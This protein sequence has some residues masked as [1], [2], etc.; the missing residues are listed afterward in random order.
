MG[1]SLVAGVTHASALM[2][3][4]MLCAISNR[5]L[6]RV[7]PTSPCSTPIAD[8]VRNTLQDL[9]VL[10]FLLGA[11]GGVWTYFVT[12]DPLDLRSLDLSARIRNILG[13]TSTLNVALCVSYS[14]F[15]A[16]GV[17]FEQGWHGSSTN[18]LYRSLPVTTSQGENATIHSN[19]PAFK[20][21][22]IQTEFHMVV[23]NGFIVSFI[24][25]TDAMDKNADATT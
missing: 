21:Q 23:K 22:S 11:F 17:L 3:G 10:T 19:S 5:W 18:K 4:V 12:C 14:I 6:A 9:V 1:F 7:L 16:F 24:D 2:L 15:F 25:S 20:K 8:T 13:G